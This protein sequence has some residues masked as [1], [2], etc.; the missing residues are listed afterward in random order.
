MAPL[1]GEF[2][3]TGLLV[4][5][6]PQLDMLLLLL[7]L[8]LPLTLPGAAGAHRTQPSTGCSLHS[9]TKPFVPCAP[10][11]LQGGAGAPACSAVHPESGHL[12]LGRPAL[13]QWVLSTHAEWL[14]FYVR[15][16]AFTVGFWDQKKCNVPL[17]SS[18]QAPDCAPAAA[19]IAHAPQ[20]HPK[21]TQPL[22]AK[23]AKP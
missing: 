13:G 23:T 1:P 17:A 16:G 19:C 9:Q 7:L 11:Q 15:L 20:P 5:L 14:C 8:L 4:L 2:F 18:R 12:L 22:T 10:D 3:V 21:P 6:L